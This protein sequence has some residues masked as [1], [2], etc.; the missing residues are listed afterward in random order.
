VKNDVIKQRQSI[1]GLGGS[2]FFKESVT[3]R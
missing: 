2:H 3:A 1:G